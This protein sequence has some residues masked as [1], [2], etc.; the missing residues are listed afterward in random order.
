MTISRPRDRRPGER[1]GAGSRSRRCVRRSVSWRYIG[2]LIVGFACHLAW[3]GEA[4]VTVRV[5]R[6]VEEAV[7]E[8]GRAEAMVSLQWPAGVEPRALV[9]WQ[10]AVDVAK[11][12]VIACAGL[13]SSD[14][15]HR[16]TSIAML[17][18]RLHASTLERIRA[19][20]GVEA[21]GRIA[22]YRPQLVES[23]PLIRARQAATEY[24]AS[25]EGVAVAII[26]TGV[27]YT[28]DELGGCLGEGCKVVAGTDIA[29]WDN[30]PMDCMG[31]GTN[32]AAIAAGPPVIPAGCASDCS[33]CENSSDLYWCTPGGVATGADIVAVK[34]FGEEDGCSSTSTDQIAGG[35]DWIL[36]NHLT[37][38]IRVI[39]LSVGGDPTRYPQYCD[40]E[41]GYTNAVKS[42]SNAG[43]LVVAAAGNDGSPKGVSYPAC[44]SRVVAVANSYDAQLV[45]EGYV[46]CWGENGCVDPMCTDKAWSADVLNCTSNGGPLIDL[47]APGTLII[48]GGYAMAGTSQ[49][50]PHVAGAGAVLMSAWPDA[51][52][53]DVRYALTISHSFVEDD[54]SGTTY[55]YPRLDVVDAL[56]VMPDVDNDGFLEDDCN[57][58]DGAVYPGAEELCNSRDDDC[59]GLVDEDFDL[60]H[61]G[62]TTCRGDCDD[63]NPLAYP[64]AVEVFG[65]PWEDCTDAVDAQ[66]PQ[67]DT[68]S[69]GCACR[70]GA[71]HGTGTLGA[72]LVAMMVLG[73]EAVRRARAR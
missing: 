15:L 16:Y 27:D 70:M 49:A 32:V 63:T 39:N 68:G 10:R 28:R 59:D 42:A 34:V 31:H 7:R 40:S 66:T 71:T 61:D 17:H 54:R 14:V 41:T 21:V 23:I 58:T 51:S 57:S 55:E 48:A 45:E 35:L 18:V 64:G 37:Y 52:P 12:R 26:D 19:C 62:Y 36:S 9:P 25:G 6:A 46:I 43:M 47:A 1:C 20:A 22:F 24:G 65:A 60:D 8:M 5:D 11:S 67:S 50:S 3:A 72:V 4:P 33:S 69:T 30:D 73:V 44:L 29:D 38:N 2:C 53:E 13:A 56:S